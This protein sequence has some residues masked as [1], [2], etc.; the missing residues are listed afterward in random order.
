MLTILK[1]TNG[2]IINPNFANEESDES[3]DG[4]YGKQ[5]SEYFSYQFLKFF[6]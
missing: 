1:D 5:I 2:A 6:L 4:E 3:S